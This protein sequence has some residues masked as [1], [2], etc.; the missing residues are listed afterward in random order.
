MVEFSIDEISSFEHAVDQAKIDGEGLRFKCPYCLKDY[1]C[2]DCDCPNI[3]GIGESDDIA[4][5]GDFDVLYRI[6]ERLKFAI[7]YKP[8]LINEV[9]WIPEWLT[10]FEDGDG[11][12]TILEQ[13]KDNH[14]YIKIFEQEPVESSHVSDWYYYVFLSPKN[15]IE[16]LTEL[17]NFRK[18]LE[19]ETNEEWEKF[20]KLNESRVKE[21]QGKDLSYNSKRDELSIEGADTLQLL[22][23]K[24]D[25]LEIKLQN[26]LQLEITINDATAIKFEDEDDAHWHISVQVS[27]VLSGSRLLDKY[28]YI[29]IQISEIISVKNLR[30][31]EIISKSVSG[32]TH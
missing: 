17:E 23:W 32:E 25:L 27:K 5:Y 20:N 8:D 29:D 22:R 14:P 4:W 7:E 26:G 12:S 21:Q 16:S 2:R 3:I 10:Y 1:G 31:G 24:A 15:R 6:Y 13:L 19:T 9:N 18:E 28:P 11:W 30:T